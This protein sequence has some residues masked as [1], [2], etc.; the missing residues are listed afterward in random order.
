MIRSTAALALLIVVAP[1]VNTN[2]CVQIAFEEILE[3]PD[4]FYK[5]TQAFADR[6]ESVL[7]AFK[8]YEAWGSERIY[9]P[10]EELSY[11]K[12]FERCKMYNGPLLKISNFNVE[13]I[14]TRINYTTLWV[15]SLQPQ[16]V[17]HVTLN[18]D[19]S[20]IVPLTT[21]PD[22][23]MPT[24]KDGQCLLFYVEKRK[25]EAR[26]CSRKSHFLCMLPH[27]IAAALLH[28]ESLGR[29]I[30]SLLQFNYTEIFVRF[31]ESVN[32][33]RV[34]EANDENKPSNLP[35][36]TFEETIQV[37]LHK[38]NMAF[39]QES[40]PALAVMIKDAVQTAERLQALDEW[41][42]IINRFLQFDHAKLFRTDNGIITCNTTRLEKPDR[43]SDPPDPW[44]NEDIHEVVQTLMNVLN[45]I[46]ATTAL[47]WQTRRYNNYK[48]REDEEPES[49]AHVRA[50]RHTTLGPE[51][52]SPDK[53]RRRVSFPRRL[54]SASAE[55]SR[56]PSSW[57]SRD[58]QSSSEETKW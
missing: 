40:M 49:R 11:S 8:D 21:G 30:E 1:V 43:G 53:K 7:K 18:A 27:E 28:Y 48:D 44:D 24:L 51:N 42:D 47:C 37:I 26:A 50:T 25:Y 55:G 6:K 23:A 22:Y 3:W 41:P 46:L 56:S 20:I 33:L 57:P 15:N 2:P 9:R 5:L 54:R 32:D 17:P 10:K 36:L 4:T 39:E 14:I 45:T 12:A 58:F 13:E 35:Y 38:E 16:E 31:A 29:R 19:D 52:R 34:Y